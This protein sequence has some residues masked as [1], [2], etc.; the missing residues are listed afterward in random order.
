VSPRGLFMVAHTAT[1]MSVFGLMVAYILYVC[2]ADGF[3]RSAQWAWA[4]AIVLANVGAMLVFFWLYIW[5]EQR[6][7]VPAAS[8]Q[9][10]S[11][12]ET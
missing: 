1:I 11:G 8:A 7:S 6:R 9:D 10:E 2:R 3:S 4:I 5:P 12:I